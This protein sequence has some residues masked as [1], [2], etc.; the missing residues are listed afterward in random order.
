MARNAA[1]RG[2]PPSTPLLVAENLRIKAQNALLKAMAK[3]PG[4]EPSA[5]YDAMTLEWRKKTI[6]LCL[7]MLAPF[8]G[9]AGQ[10]LGRR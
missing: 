3:T 6:E 4:L 2:E 8:V 10:I 9:N 7:K 1:S 5:R